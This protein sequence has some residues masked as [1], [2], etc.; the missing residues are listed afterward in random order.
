M[1]HIQRI[2][3]AMALQLH[4]TV[5]SPTT[6]GPICPVQ[7]QR[8]SEGILKPDDCLMSCREYTP[9]MDRH[10]HHF[11]WKSHETQAWFYHENSCGRSSET[12]PTKTAEKLTK[13]RPPN[14][15]LMDAL[16]PQYVCW[17]VLCS[18]YDDIWWHM[19]TTRRYPGEKCMLCFWCCSNMSKKQDHANNLS[20]FLPEQPQNI[21]I[22]L[23]NPIQCCDCRRIRSTLSA[24]QQK[25]PAGIGGGI[26]INPASDLTHGLVVRISIFVQ[27]LRTYK[28]NRFIWCSM[29]QFYMLPHVYII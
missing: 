20:R 28:A 16:I 8:L 10:G 4:W 27:Q 1:G 13:S 17:I 12:N 24:R 19:M 21:A 25:N 5:N 18:W 29:F 14:H 6:H 26:A 22:Q 15:V 2:W 23:S 9:S 7:I 3:F 11:H